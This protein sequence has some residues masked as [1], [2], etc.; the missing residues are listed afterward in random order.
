MPQ[1]GLCMYGQACQQD[2]VRRD[3]A[4]LSMYVVFVFVWGCM[5]VAW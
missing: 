5:P 3:E 4:H 2:R 1:S